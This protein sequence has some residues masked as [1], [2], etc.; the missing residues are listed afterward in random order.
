MMDVE[1]GGGCFWMCDDEIVVGD[2]CCV[3]DVGWL[4]AVVDDDCE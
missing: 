3:M 4:I 1:N 2:G